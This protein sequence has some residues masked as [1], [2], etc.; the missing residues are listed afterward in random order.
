MKRQR[1]DGHV[2]QI[3][4]PPVNTISEGNDPFAGGVK[5]KPKRPKGKKIS[6]S[7][8]G[9]PSDFRHLSHVGFDP[10]TGAFDVSVHVH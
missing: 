5:T 4:K 7:D 8:I 10:S 2:T 6:K 3:G 1:D 9:A